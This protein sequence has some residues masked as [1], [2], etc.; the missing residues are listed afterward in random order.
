[1]PLVTPRTHRCLGLAAMLCAVAGAPRTLLAQRQGQRQPPKFEN[2]K[3]FP[4]DIPR[5]SLLGHM[6]GFTRALGVRCQYCHVEDSASSPGGRRRLDFPLDDKATKRKARFMLR[7]VDSLNNVVLASLPDRRTPPVMIQC[8]TC[9][10]GSPYPQ[11]LE[12]VMMAA[13]DQYGVDSAVTRYKTLREDMVSGRYDF[14]EESLSE[15]A[16]KLGE[17]GK[18]TDAIALLKLNQQYYPN[19][20]NIDFAMAE[21]YRTSGN[22]DQAIAEY[23]VVLEKRPNDRRAAQRLKQMEASSSK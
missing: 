15:I 2:L 1:M 7:M 13:V 14:S 3:Y 16:G 23:R 11:T 5:D 21:L 20:A 19:S 10:R 8:V 22:R 12:T 17:Q 18:T 4:K 6:H 9:H